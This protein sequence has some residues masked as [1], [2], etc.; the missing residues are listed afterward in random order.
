ML[1]RTTSGLR[2]ELLCGCP[3]LLETRLLGCLHAAQVAEAR[4]EAA[5]SAYVTDQLSYS[6]FWKLL[7]FG[8]KLDGLL[9]VRT[10]LGLRLP[11][12]DVWFGWLA[13]QGAHISNRLFFFCSCGPTFVVLLA[14]SG[15]GISLYW[16]C[17]NNACT[18]A[19]A[20]TQARSTVEVMR[21]AGHAGCK[22]SNIMQHLLVYKGHGVRV[23][24][25][26]AAGVTSL[27]GCSRC[28]REVGFACNFHTLTVQT[29]PLFVSINSHTCTR[30]Y[31]VHVHLCS[32]G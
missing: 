14:G 6:K 13:A 4:R 32:G 17:I 2:V 29:V 30:M 25:V 16:A 27:T 9:K 15:L 5:L 21:I 20:P 3:F 23:L 22:D 26:E 8:D 1:R 11:K 12:I 31:H 24:S 7:E 18:L 28:A 10:R 19:S